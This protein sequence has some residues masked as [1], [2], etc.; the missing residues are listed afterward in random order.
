MQLYKNVNSAFKL[1]KAI[2]IITLIAS[3]ASVITIV[4]AGKSERTELLSRLDRTYVIA[5]GQALQ[6]EAAQP[7]AADRKI[8]AIGHITRFHELFFNLSPDQAAIDEKLR[9]ALYLIDESGNQHHAYLKENKF[10]TTL[11]SQNIRQQLIIPDQ[12][13]KIDTVDYDVHFTFTCTQLLERST[14]LTERELITRGTIR[15]V[16]RSENNTHGMLIAN[17]QVVSNHDIRVL[18]K[19]PTL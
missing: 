13:V 17:W 15:N 7:S 5:N 2:T 11:V 3:F 9:Q 6:V 19:D 18:K 4:L 10:Y 1:S 16:D 8:E 12:A 14:S